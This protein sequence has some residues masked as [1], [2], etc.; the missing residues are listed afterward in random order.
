MM[1]KGVKVLDIEPIIYLGDKA[2]DWSYNQKY[3]QKELGKVKHKDSWGIESP[4]DDMVC[5]YL[6]YRDKTYNP[7]TEESTVDVEYLI[8]AYYILKQ[9]FDNV[10]INFY[11]DND[12]EGVGN[13]FDMTIEEF[14]EYILLEK[15]L[16]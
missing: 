4:I 7:T 14:K 11:L 6:P 13:N 2:K 15:L 8:E 16:K 5:I 3:V 12:I 10:Q 1:Y 9:V